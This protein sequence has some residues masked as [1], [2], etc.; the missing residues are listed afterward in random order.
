MGDRLKSIGMH[1]ARYGLAIM[2][3]W[4]GGMMFTAYQAVGIKPL[5]VNSPLMGWAYRVMSVGG[6]SSLLGVVEIALGVLIALRPVWPLGSAVGSGL[7]AG[8]FLTTLSFLVTT[9]GGG[10]SLGGFPALSAMPGQFLLQDVVLLGVALSSAGEA[11]EAV[12]R[13]G[14]LVAATTQGAVH[15][16]QGCLGKKGG[17]SPGS[18]QAMRPRIDLVTATAICLISAL[19][20]GP[21]GGDGKADQPA[22]LALARPYSRGKI[23][24]ILIHGLG[25]S[26][27]SW[28][29]MIEALEADPSLRE[30]YQFWTFDYATCAPILYSAHLL[31]QDLRAARGRLDPDRTDSAFDHMVLIGHSMGG[32]LAKM[33]AQDSRSNLWELRSP[34]PFEKLVGPPEDRDLLREVVFFKSRPEVRRLIFIATPHRGSR[35]D[36]GIIRRVGG[37]LCRLPDALKQVHQR[38]LAR[39]GP[40]FFTPMLRGRLPTSIDQ[41]AWEHPELQALV[42]LG[43]DPGVAYHSIMADFRDPPLAGGTDGVVSYASAHLDGASSEL[44]VHGGH[45][46]QADPLVIREVGRILTEH[47]RLPV[48]TRLGGRPQDD[49]F[50]YR[51][52]DEAARPCTTGFPRIPCGNGTEGECE[53]TVQ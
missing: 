26:P 52:S 13:R 1:V 38:L 41:L 30:R 45:L 6:F 42:A 5:V 43:I 36:R 14:A 10:P 39:N 40:A 29:P 9:P 23:P 47:L 37:R 17:S 24:V 33:M 7:A 49:S 48:A 2:L 21:A 53:I 34:Q 32:L 16:D 19:G 4:I 8:M 22:G 11:L 31:R 15:N 35:L 46:C 50:R 18:L 20:A 12:R 44:L 28:A 3:L 25:S 51:A 27:K